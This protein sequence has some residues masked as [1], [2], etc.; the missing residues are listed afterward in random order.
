MIEDILREQGENC[1]VSGFSEGGELINYLRRR[2]GDEDIVFID[3]QLQDESGIQVAKSINNFFSHTCVIFVT[4]HISYA[5]DI[6][7]AKP[8]YFLLKP[9]VKDKLEAALA[10][11]TEENRHYNKG[12]TVKI[13]SKGH[14]FHLR[15][16]YIKYISSDRRVAL[17]HNCNGSLKIYEKLDNLQQSLGGKFLRCHQSYIVN[18]DCIRS[19]DQQSICLYTGEVIPV[20]KRRY[21]MAKSA[22]LKY[23]GDSL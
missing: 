2:K 18:M 12:N 10:M 22:F 17:I 14:V 13:C 1:Q 6:F 11:A 5:Q 8:T 7:D 15:L 3:I 9:V 16:N 4:G 21:A 20:S 19:F 23:L